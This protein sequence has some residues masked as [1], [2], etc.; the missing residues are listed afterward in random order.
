MIMF[1]VIFVKGSV[2]EGCLVSLFGLFRWIGES[3]LFCFGC[4]GKGKIVLVVG[5]S[6]VEEIVLI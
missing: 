1:V 5:G 2:D 3:Y 4:C 6:V